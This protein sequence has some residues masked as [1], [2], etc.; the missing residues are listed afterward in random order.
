MGDE[1][2]QVVEMEYKG[3][4]Y[5]IKGTKA[6]I[7]SF[8]SMIKGL[9]DWS[10]KRSI[11]RP[12]ESSWNKIQEASDGNATIV[13]IPVE[14]FE[15]NKIGPNGEKT[16][17][18]DKYMKENKL[19][20]CI[21]PDFN[22]YD[23]YVPVGIV[24]Q[25]Y[26][27]HAAHIK[28]Y[29]A[30]RVKN[31]KEHGQEFEAKLTD[32]K[33]RLA[34]ARSEEEKKEI[35]EEI[36]SLEQ[37]KD[38]NKKLLDE[39]EEKMNKGNVIEFEEYLKSGMDTKFGDNPKEAL[40]EAEALSD[41]ETFDVGKEFLPKNCMYP[42]RDKELVPK[43]KEIYYSQMASDQSIYTVRRE[44]AED[45]HGLIFST[46]YVTNAKNAAEVRIFSDK[47]F[48]KEAWE[49]QL[50][51]LLKDSGMV[52]NAPTTAIHGE[53]RLESYI[54]YLDRNFNRTSEALDAKEVEEPSSTKAKEFIDDV[55]KEKKQTAYYEKSLFTTFVVPNTAVMGS[56][57]GVPSLEIAQGMLVGVSIGEFN[58]NGECPVSIKSNRSYTLEM[59]DGSTDTIKGT[60]AIQMIKEAKKAKETQAK[61]KAASRK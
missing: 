26:A 21:M 42:I 50:P 55:K 14:M 48:T 61:V 2:S 13:E 53:E 1:I 59:P 6:F 17:A 15:Q 56:K 57:D 12:G 22:P 47:G 4:Y 29:M 10:H 35:E 30:L 45:D 39:S 31:Q 18:F 58:E 11:K 9:A 37:A 41:G 38:E 52:A 19:R 44:F 24:S 16:C 40:E 23:D 20:Y 51:D 34:N 7:T 25:D 49:E 36:V 27:I 46:Y 32:A 8:A 28:E 3:I 60:D 5:L 43:S 54:R 33:Q